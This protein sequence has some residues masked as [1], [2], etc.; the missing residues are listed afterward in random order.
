M[1]NTTSGSSSPSL[2]ASGNNYENIKSKASPW[3]EKRRSMS[4]LHR[5]MSLDANSPNQPV[6][7]I[8]GNFPSSKG[9]LNIALDNNSPQGH[10]SHSLPSSRYPSPPT[11]PTFRRVSAVSKS[12]FEGLPG[13]KRSSQEQFEYIPPKEDK[14]N[15]VKKN[16][17]LIKEIE[18]KSLNASKSYKFFEE[19]ILNPKLSGNRFKRKS[20]VYQLNLLSSESDTAE[21]TS[22]SMDE[23]PADKFQR[24]KHEVDTFVSEMENLS[25][26]QKK[27]LSESTSFYRTMFEKS[28][29]LQKQLGALTENKH[30]LPGLLSQ[31][32]LE[33]N[34]LQV[35]SSLDH[36]QQAMGIM[37]EQQV[38]Q[39]T[40]DDGTF[41][42]SKSSVE[43]EETYKIL[44]LEK[45]LALLE[46]LVGNGEESF[47][48]ETSSIES[49]LSSLEKK[50]NMLDPF[51]LQSLESRVK[52]ISKELD[53]I[54]TSENH[55]SFNSE[56]V[57]SLFQKVSK[58]DELAKQVPMIVS[59]LQ[60]LKIVHDEAIYF[61]G[62]VTKLK[63]QQEE[64]MDLLHGN[65]D[66]LAN[67]NQNFAENLTIINNNM[68]SLQERI[69]NLEKK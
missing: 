36:A 11:S 9:L 38:N 4:L 26:S 20:A 68:K 24:L 12:L 6:S 51:L 30:I 31:N 58:W 62:T 40:I 54:S 55:S 2:S 25:L 37:F 48:G 8:P 41:A 52:F 57:D 65:E 66:V 13:F 29:E 45:R 16:K 5:N 60:T 69:K 17:P 50:L 1:E 67:F 61:A 56:K 34:S 23:S 42:L 15:S 28:Q 46:K 39:A 64:L 27:L 14:Q 21:I 10:P 47:P 33:A 18:E 7:P 3:L 49:V 19:V 63:E 53:T 43:D 59:R 44:R 35:L 22:H 32:E